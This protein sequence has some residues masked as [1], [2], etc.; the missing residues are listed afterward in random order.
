MMEKVKKFVVLPLGLFIGSLVLSLHRNPWG[1]LRNFR[2]DFWQKTGYFLLN[3]FGSAAFIL[4]IALLFVFVFT[5]RNIADLFKKPALKAMGI[6]F[7]AELIAKFLLTDVLMPLLN[8]NELEAAK[9]GI[10]MNEWY[11]VIVHGLPS[12]IVSFGV[13]YFTLR[14]LIKPLNLSF[15]FHGAS[16]FLVLFLN[17]A[18]PILESYGT[19]QFVNHLNASNDVTLETVRVFN[20]TV[21][22]NVFNAV[23]AVVAAIIVAIIEGFIFFFFNRCIK[24]NQTEAI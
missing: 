3:L 18:I 23:W 16:F 21:G 11:M 9:K 22:L 19:L 7:T 24:Q 10:R 15:S 8:R 20:L 2:L 5:N 14:L 1:Y 4:L 17:L 12:I 6:V 13:V